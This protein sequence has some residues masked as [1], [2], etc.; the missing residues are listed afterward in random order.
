MPGRASSAATTLRGSTWWS[1]GSTAPPRIR[2]VHGDRAAPAGQPPGDGQPDDAGAD[3]RDPHHAPTAQ[4]SCLVAAA[5]SAA[6]LTA[7]TTATPYA[8]AASTVGIRSAVM[9]PIAM[10]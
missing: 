1:S 10:T 2:V 5:G 6:S 7:L 3:D 9:A 8:P 4:S